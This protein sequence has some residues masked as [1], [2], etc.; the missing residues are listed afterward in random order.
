M[1]KGARMYYVGDRVEDLA[2][3]TVLLAPALELGHLA[4]DGPLAQVQHPVDM[5][6]QFVLPHDYANPHARY[7]PRKQNILQRGEEGLITT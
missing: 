7:G 1:W 4:V 2:Y 6:H 3:E 5:R